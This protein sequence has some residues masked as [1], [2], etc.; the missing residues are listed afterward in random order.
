[1]LGLDEEEEEEATAVAALPTAISGDKMMSE[2][3]ELC[4]FFLRLELLLERAAP[5]KLLR[6]D[7]LSLLCS[8]FGS[9]RRKM[10]GEEG[11][12]S[13]SWSTSLLFS[14]TTAGAFPFRERLDSMAFKKMR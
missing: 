14:F 4:R 7:F 6:L 10:G 5:D 12:L 1:L 3:V 13:V 2:M 9:F 11:G 8:F